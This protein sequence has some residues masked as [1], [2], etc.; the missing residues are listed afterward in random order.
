M[1]LRTS[2]AT[3]AAV[4]TGIVGTTFAAG[5][6]MADITD[7]ANY[8]GT[9]CMAEN[10]DWGGQ[11]WR[12]YPNQISGCRPL[13]RDNFNNKAT[14]LVNNTPGQVVM[15]LYDNADCTGASISLNSQAVRSLKND[16]FNDKASSIRVIQL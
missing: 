10:F 6:A 1:R 12:Q 15:Y 9:I 3:T 11:I 14:D 2:I 4:F 8:P 16:P 13:S 7:C 5:P